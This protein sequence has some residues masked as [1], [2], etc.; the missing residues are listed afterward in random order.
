MEMSKGHATK[1][2]KEE[3]EW[4]KENCKGVMYKDLAHM[5]NQ[6]F[7]KNS[8]PKNLSQKLYRMGLRN[9]VDGRFSK[10]LVPWNK[11]LKGYMGPNETSFKKG[12]IPP[13]LRPVGSRRQDRD[14]Y[15]LEKLESG[16]WELVHRVIWENANGPIPDGHAVIFKDQNSNNLNIDNLI[17]VNR[18]ELLILN[19]HNLLSDETVITEVGVNVAKLIDKTNKVKKEKKSLTDRTDREKVSK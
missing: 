19:R 2:T 10:G 13:N 4:L 6:R 7:N 1:Y 5:F 12:D 3:E 16:K 18:S 9:G 14:G 17:L 15:W 8:K 11:G